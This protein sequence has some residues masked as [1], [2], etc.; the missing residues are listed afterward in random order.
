MEAVWTHFT[1]DFRERICMESRQTAARALAE[2]H[3]EGEHTTP[4]AFYEQIRKRLNIQLS[5]TDTAGCWLLGARPLRRVAQNDATLP[6]HF[7]ND[8]GGEW[9]QYSAVELLSLFG[10]SYLLQGLEGWVPPPHPQ[11]AQKPH[12]RRGPRLPTPTRAKTTRASGTPAP[13]LGFRDKSRTHPYR[14]GSVI[15]RLWRWVPAK[16]V[17]N[18]DHAGGGVHGFNIDFSAV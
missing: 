2:Q 3:R 15:S 7:Q 1:N 4:V 10:V 5:K 17:E 9:S 18:K 11:R 12:A 8:P 6:Q 13:G 16:A 14:V